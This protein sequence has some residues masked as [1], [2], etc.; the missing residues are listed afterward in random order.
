MKQLQR[1]I[2]HVKIS[3]NAAFSLQLFLFVHVPP[4]FSVLLTYS[5]KTNSLLFDPPCRYLDWE[6]LIVFSLFDIDF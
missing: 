3:D 6:Y 2:F 5:L 4:V 1:K